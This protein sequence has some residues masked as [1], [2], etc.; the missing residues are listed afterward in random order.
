MKQSTK[1]L[2]VCLSVLLLHISACHLGTWNAAAFFVTGSTNGIRTKKNAYKENCPQ[3]SAPHFLPVER[4]VTIALLLRHQQV[5]FWKRKRK[6]P[7]IIQ[8][9]S[10]ASDYL[11]FYFFLHWP[12][13]PRGGHNL[14]WWRPVSKRALFLVHNAASPSKPAST[15]FTS[16]RL[17]GDAGLCWSAS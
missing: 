9:P 8:L 5:D 11:F 6:K 1:F 17:A 4:P 2:Y 16:L 3:T 10:K 13:A 12:I 7:H 14:T 15:I